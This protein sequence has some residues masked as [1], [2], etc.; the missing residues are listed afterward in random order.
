[1]Y[2]YIYQVKQLLAEVIVTINEL[3]ADG[4]PV[5]NVPLTMVCARSSH[6]DY[7]RMYRKCICFQAC[8]H[9]ACAQ[10]VSR[11]F[12]DKECSRC[13]QIIVNDLL[14]CLTCDPIAI[15]C[16]SCRVYHDIT[17]SLRL[18]RVPAH[19]TPAHQVVVA[20][21]QLEHFN[22]ADIQAAIVRA[23]SSHFVVERVQR[24]VKKRKGRPPDS[25]TM[26]FVTWEG[27]WPPNEKKTEEK[28]SSLAEDMQEEFLEQTKGR[29]TYQEVNFSRIPA[30]VARVPLVPQ[31]NRVEVLTDELD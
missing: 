25:E 26:V 27:T 29:R 28:L 6:V 16:L 4:A 18:D 14:T 19:D 5:D 23:T 20:P 21:I 8:T 30:L 12:S 15:F 24:V 13:S 22:E 11:I 3:L 7:V 10:Q 17:H 9:C 1:M 31:G 2:A